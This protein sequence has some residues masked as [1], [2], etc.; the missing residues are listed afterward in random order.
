MFVRVTVKAKA[1]KDQ[2][3]PKKEGKFLIQ[4]RQPAKEGRA[5][6]QVCLLLANY[7][8]VPLERI[9][10]IRGRTCPHKLFEIRNYDRKNS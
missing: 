9:K 7:L 1:K 4:T 3:F 6:Q 8:G 2:V 5:N 10:L